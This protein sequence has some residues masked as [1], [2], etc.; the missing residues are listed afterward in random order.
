MVS[1]MELALPL[2][3]PCSVFCFGLVISLLG[4][5]DGIKNGVGFTAG[6]TLFRV[7]LVVGLGVVFTGLLAAVSHLFTNISADIEI[8]MQQFGLDVTSGEHVLF[9]GFPRQRR[10]L[11]AG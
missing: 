7:L 1:K 8:I 5:D 10:R 11:F 9:D 3:L 6:V 2:V 4:K